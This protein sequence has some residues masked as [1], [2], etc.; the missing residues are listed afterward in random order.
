MDFDSLEKS[1]DRALQHT[2]CKM[3]VFVCACVL[4]LCG[5]LVIFSMGLSLSANAWIAQSLF[6]LPLFVC[7]A[8]L[9]ALGI[10]L[11]RAYHHQIK[12]RLVNY[13]TL[14]ME[15]WEVALSASYCFIPLI[16]AYMALW[17]VLGVFFLLRE[18]PLLGEFFGVVFAFG[19]FILHFT[20]FVLL[21]LAGYILFTLAPLFAL[22]PFP[23]KFVLSYLLSALKESIF[24]RVVLISVACIP[25]GL[26]GALLWLS[27]HMTS[28]AYLTQEKH[29]HMILQW[30]FILPPLALILAF[31]VIF[32]FNM[33][34]EAHIA[35]QKK[36]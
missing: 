15:S 12:H 8:V 33:A 10:V 24:Q 11:I 29:T 6:F 26:I 3:K 1:C 22:R 4:A 23:K 25:V 28:L 5:F 19:P 34:A 7:A 31:P 36:R 13:R 18:M 16:A 27:A 17:I 2:W 30:L 35:I 21:A 32:F 20:S 9:A 14:A